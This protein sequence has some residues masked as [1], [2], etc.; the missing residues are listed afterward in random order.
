MRQVWTSSGLSRVVPTSWAG[1]PQRVPGPLRHA[2]RVLGPSGNSIRGP[3]RYQNDRNHGN[4]RKWTQM[5]RNGLRIRPFEAHSL[6]TA[7][8]NPP[9]P[10]ILSEQFKTLHVRKNRK[11]R[12]SGNPPGSAEMGGAPLII[13]ECSSMT[14]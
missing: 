3:E 9:R 8:A 1:H 14:S 13:L 6:F 4:R 2:R 10:Q 7:I 12:K 5:A 11:I